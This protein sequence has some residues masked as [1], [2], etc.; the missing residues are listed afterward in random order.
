MKVLCIDAANR[1]NSLGRAK[2]TEGKTYTV[3]DECEGY[4]VYDQPVGECYILDEF[5]DDY[6]FT[7]DRFIPLSNQDELQLIEINE[8]TV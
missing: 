6:C 1:H 3:V 4:D 7:K 5:P 2:L 8:T